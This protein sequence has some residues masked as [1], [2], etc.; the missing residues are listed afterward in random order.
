MIATGISVIG[1]LLIIIQAIFRTKES[2][3][4]TRSLYKRRLKYILWILLSIG[5][6]I[7]LFEESSIINFI[8]S[9]FDRTSY[10]CTLFIVVTCSQIVI[11]DMIQ[12]NNHFK[13]HNSLCIKQIKLDFATATMLILY[14]FMLYLGIL[15]FIDFDIYHSHIILQGLFICSFI[16]TLY[17]INPS[18]G[19]LALI[20][21][22][23]FSVFADYNESPLESL[24]C[25][26]LWLYCAAYILTKI[27]IYGSRLPLWRHLA[28][29]KF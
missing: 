23:L 14:G 9:F 21:L 2:K 27:L 3:Y 29:F 18:F 17:S 16:L 5:C 6:F 13:I 22:V 12:N 4:R 19:I 25:P 15:G 24:I 20:A 8:Y 26:Y 10:L 11:A 1:I 28:S 7:P